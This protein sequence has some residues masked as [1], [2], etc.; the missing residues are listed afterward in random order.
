MDRAAPVRRAPHRPVHRRPGA[1]P[2]DAVIHLARR[3]GIDPPA[4]LLPLARQATD[5]AIRARV[6]DHLGFTL[7]STDAQNRLEAD[8][9]AV[10]ADGLTPADLIQRAEASLSAAKVILPARTTLERLVAAITRQ[11]LDGLFNRIAARLPA[12]LRAAL[13]RLVGQLADDAGTEGRASLGRYRTPSAASM[14]RFTREPASGWTRSRPCWPT[15]PI[16]PICRG[17]L[18]RAD[19]QRGAAS[20][21]EQSRL[22][23]GMGAL[24]EVPAQGASRR[25]V[26]GD[27]PL[28]ASL[29]VANTEVAGAL[30]QLDVGKMQHADLADA[31]TG[32][33]EQLHE[34]VVA[35]SMTVAGGAGGAQQAVNFCPGQADRLA[36]ALGTDRLD[37]PADIGPKPALG[38]GPTAQ[39]AQR[40]EPPVHGRR[41][42][43]ALPDQVMP[44]GDELELAQRRNC[45]RPWAYPD[46]NCRTSLR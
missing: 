31:E 5:S 36:I 8:L 42:Q 28:P 33:D 11:A 3:L 12:S 44:I 30:T 10:A 46:R 27:L 43:A 4:R 26:E 34:G 45:T 39:A 35:A 16:S 9:S 40:F 21:Q 24:L 37:R 1:G 29:A 22:G 25:G 7:F 6:R 20:A 15:C 18:D 19:R 38:I 23:A 41:A 14:G 32:L 13:D 17:D 2:A